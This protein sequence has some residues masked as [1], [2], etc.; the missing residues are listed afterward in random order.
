VNSSPSPS[1]KRAVLR[2]DGSL[3]AG[4]RVALEISDR[5]LLSEAV[6]S[7]PAAPAIIKALDEWR[8]SYRQ[9]LKQARISLESVTVE[10]GSLCQLET[11]RD[12]S[13]VLATLLKKWLSHPGFQEI[14]QRLRESLNA[15]DE[16]EILLRTLDK[17]LYQLPWHSWG[18]IERYPN[19]ELVLSIPSERL[20][21]AAKPYPKVRIL[22]ILG[23]RR[24]IDTET[25]RQ[26]LE[27]MPDAEVMFLV[28]P[29]RQFL[30]RY[31]WEQSWD[32]LFFAGHSHTLDQQGIIN[33]NSQEQLSL[34]D[35][36]YGLRKA[37][38]RGLQL[39]IFNSC[40][41][42]GL[43]QELE[44][45]HIPQ[46]IV[47]REPVPD[48]VAQEFLKRFLQ[49][50]SS[51]ESLIASVRQSREW[52][53]SLEG[54]FPCASWLPILFQNPAM[55]PLR[56]NVMG[57]EESPAMDLPE[58]G[59]PSLPGRKLRLRG[60]LALGLMV[61]TL[62]GVGRSFGWLEPMEL[63]AYDQ[64]VR[65]QF[66]RAKPGLQ[67]GQK[68]RIVGVTPQDTQKYGAGMENVISD[69]ALAEVITKIDK[70]QPKVIGLDI[71]RDIPQP[72]VAGHN[73]LVK[74]L[75]SSP[76]MVL[77]C[78]VGEEDRG[79]YQATTS[80]GT[81][82]LSMPK[83]IGYADS[84][85]GDKDTVVRRYIIE[86]GS[87][88]GSACIADKSF[89]WQIAQRAIEPIPLKL[90]PNLAADFG[91]YQ[92]NP[93]Q[94]GEGQLLINYHA[95][96]R[97]I[98]YYSVTDILSLSTEG[99]LQQLFKDNI[100]LIG[101]NVKGK[102]QH[103]TPVGLQNGVLLHAHIIRQLLHQTPQIQSLPQWVE[104]LGIGSGAMLGSLLLWKV[105]S[106]RRRLFW[107]VSAVFC[108]QVFTAGVYYLQLVWVPTVPVILALL[109]SVVLVELLEKVG[110]RLSRSSRGVSAQS[111]APAKVQME[112][113][114]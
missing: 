98:K 92:G 78:L 36:K 106:V 40:D 85:L 23:D 66:Y 95:S 69:R 14:E 35:L 48:R 94:F 110:W 55:E 52:L 83:P 6:G 108:L 33:I 68:I 87:R 34:E 105:R 47:M 31:L 84:L 104:S 90:K 43:A 74:T 56:W 71:F 13:K 91:G 7:L 97:N 101:Y 41:G 26:I 45:L 57:Q 38:Q 77:A 29:S 86:M 81:P 21:L 59:R 89:A 22:A 18:F 109:I 82:K 79:E 70:Y 107:V 3:E 51:G 103:L 72:N 8:Q 67:D 58:S 2:L 54:D 60:I 27:Q 19:A 100:V 16:V 62:V 113:V 63:W 53:Q 15:N 20:D 96:M 4:F 64:S 11:C 114:E 93:E 28:E 102:D 49:T 112:N 5:A 1:N 111:I 99:E 32:I 10:T 61:G 30:Y 9:G 39:A 42:L 46:F 88:A 76:N 44:Q 75:Q 65:L 17:R 25:D 73:Q 24:G 12:L 37:I 50:F 80:I